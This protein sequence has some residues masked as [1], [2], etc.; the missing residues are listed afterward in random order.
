VPLSA[1]VGRMLL[2]V[3]L[4][5]AAAVERRLPWPREQKKTVLAVVSLVVAIGSLLAFAFLAFPHEPPIHPHSVLPRPSDLLPA[6]LFLAPAVVLYRSGHRDRAAFDAALVWLAG[7]SA[8]CHFIVT[9]SV[10]WFDG[11]AG[12]AQLL[13]IGSYA[14]LLGATLV[15]NVRLFGQV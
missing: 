4:L 12:G 5:I 11:P 9:E 13:K 10:R 7:A 1:V 15:D 6:G 3:L 8:T 14:G 2:A